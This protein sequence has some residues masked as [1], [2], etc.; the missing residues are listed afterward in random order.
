MKSSA[1]VLGV[2]LLLDALFGEPPN[3]LHPVAWMGRLLAWG[4]RHTPRHSRSAELLYGALLTLCG[5]MLSASAALLVQS[6]AARLPQPLGWVVAGAAL[7]A[8]FSIRGLDEAAGQ[9][10]AALEREDL[11]EAQR[12]VAR[13]LVSR[14]TAQLTTSQTAAAA[15][16]SV[17][18]NCSDGV[19]APL[20]YYALG[21]LPLASVYR[22]ANTADSMLGYR[23]AAHEWLGKF[24]ARLDDLLNLIPARVS[25]VLITMAAWL[26]GRDDRG[27]W[28]AMRR[29]ARTTASP[30]AGYPMAAMAG[31]L[32][33]EL[34]KVGHYRLGAGG[35]AASASNLREARELL[36]LAACLAALLAALVA[37]LRLA[38][39]NAYSG[40]A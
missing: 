33:V 25:G 20:F 18:E 9:V 31:A 40:K 6:L 5:G 10:Q 38:R 39:P 13:H 21:G 17:A 27:A 11:P 12:L 14:E 26:S 3:R 1:A 32:G 28:R 15:I 8:S 37:V 4:E 7:K 29:E 35:R 2:A 30:N 23:D 16:E 36:R 24:P 22:F 34:E 19:T